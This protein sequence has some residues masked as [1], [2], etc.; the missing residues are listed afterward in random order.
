[1]QA[2]QTQT[3]QSIQRFD[4]KKCLNGVSEP[5]NIVASV[6]V[7]GSLGFS[8]RL[9]A[10][11]VPGVLLLVLVAKVPSHKCGRY[12]DKGAVGDVDG[13]TLEVSGLVDSGVDERT[14]DTTSVT[15]G[16]DDSG[17]DT[18][19]ERTTT[20]VGPP[21]DNHRNK[22]VDT[23]SCQEH[24]DVVDSGNLG[25]NQKEESKGADGSEKHGD[26]PTLLESIRH[27]TSDDGRKGGQNVG[28]GRHLDRE[29]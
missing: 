3:I 10:S 18:L 13:V 16:D 2:T 28:R 25:D 20:V 19:L 24:A 8:P 23:G 15:D 21:G 1:M 29:G 6:L 5:V 14:D 12:N 17:G 27:V 4:A 26:D 7:L 11:G 22:R 9:V